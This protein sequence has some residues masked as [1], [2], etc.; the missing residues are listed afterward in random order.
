MTLTDLETLPD[1]RGWRLVSPPD[2]RIPLSPRE[3][4][5]LDLIMGGR[6]Q[7]E[8]AFE[9]RLS[10]ATVRVLYARAMKKL[11][12]TELKIAETNRTPGL[13]LETIGR[14]QGGGFDPYNQRGSGKRQG[15]AATRAGITGSADRGS[16]L[17]QLTGKKK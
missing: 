8:A 16:V 6:S 11:G 10:D 15:E 9:L 17:D 2:S 13:K 3:R 12:V 4:Q 7:K 14:D 1:V 5:I